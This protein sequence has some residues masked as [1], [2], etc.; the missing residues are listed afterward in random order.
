M[1]LAYQILDRRNKKLIG[2]IYVEDG[3]YTAELVRN[4]D[5]GP[6]PI[7]FGFPEP[8]SRRNPPS[9]AIENFLKSR[10]IPSNRQLL[11]K[12][13]ES[14]NMKEYNWKELIKFNQGRSSGDVYMVETIE[15]E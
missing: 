12:V 15:D 3:K 13:L 1:K 4:P 9:W 5:E 10:V 2:N 11:D 8:G 6:I 7:L 14:H